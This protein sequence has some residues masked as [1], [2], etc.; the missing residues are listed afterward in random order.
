MLHLY[1]KSVQ[2]HITEKIVIEGKYKFWTHNLMSLRR[3]LYHYA[4]TFEHF[5]TLALIIAQYTYLDMQPS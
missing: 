3:L 1:Q 5:C 4:T 2:G